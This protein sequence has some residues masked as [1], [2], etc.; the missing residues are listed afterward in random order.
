M[1]GTTTDRPR[2]LTELELIA[3]MAML[4]ATV[5]FSIDAMLPALPE[6]GAALS[7]DAPNRAQLIITSFVLGMGLGTF[8]SG[9]LADQFGRKATVIAGSSLYV[10]GAALAGMSGSIEGM[11]AARVLQ[12]LGASFPRVVAMAII[13]DLYSGRAMARLLSFV[14]LVFS[15]VPAIAPT[16]GY[17]IIS[18]WGWRAIFAAF[19]VFSV[20]SLIWLAM[21]LPE[22]LP[23]DARRPVR[24]AA[25][26][27]AIAQMLAHPTVRLSIL[28]QT[29]TF[30]MLFSLLSSTQ[31]IFDVTYGRG[32]SFHLWFGGIAVVSATSSILNARLVVRLGMRAIIKGMLIVQI[33]LSTAMALAVL[34]PLPVSVEFVLFV[35]WN[36]SVFFQAGMTIGNLNALGMEPMGHIAG[37]AAS[38]LSAVSTVGA[39][40]IAVPI[41]LAFNGTPMPVAFGTA[42]CA[43]I[44]YALTLRIRRDS[45]EDQ[46]A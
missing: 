21:R 4:A 33:F 38:V 43:A 15:L 26:R 12:G 19:I 11:L 42:V 10:I 1:T 25:L 18:L 37:M 32:H 39:V 30:G 46:T 22:T 24:V 28:V 20:L 5:A 41:G 14:M 7:P 13:R 3:M 40:I 9:P 2:K 44:A 6:I 34:A 31:Q 29:L 35:I 17:G 36:T 16:L 27:D 23:A 8:I 45:D